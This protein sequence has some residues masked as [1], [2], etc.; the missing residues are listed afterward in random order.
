[1][2]TPHS[3]SSTH[4]K[5]LETASRLFYEQGYHLTG[6]NQVIAEAGVA[7][8]SFYYHF[9]SKEDLCIAYLE[10]R[11]QDWFGWLREEIDQ[12]KEPS[13]R[14][15]SLFTF[16]ERWLS[17]SDFRG[18]AFLNITAEFPSPDNKI[19]L[20]V[21]SH[22]DALQAYITQLVDSLDI[23]ASENNSAY[24]VNAI[25]L[26]FEGTICQCQMYRTTEFIQSTKGI[27]NQLISM[28]VK[29]SG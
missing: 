14:L 22:K 10:K 2:K 25:Y 16:L 23:P 24:L 12:S 28:K 9:S 6:I 3:A 27:V 26:L 21:V 29:A 1:M 5:I 11:H 20:L 17:N 4:T 15:L 8:A 7:K 18:C 13:E 19:R